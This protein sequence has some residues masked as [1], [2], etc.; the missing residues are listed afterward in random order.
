MQ[1]LYALCLGLL[2]CSIGSAASPTAKHDA[3]LRALKNSEPTVKDAVWTSPRVLKVGVLDTGKNR[4]G[5]A[6]YLCEVIGEHGLSG[7]GISVQVIDIAK[8]VKTDKW[9]KL[10]E[11]QCR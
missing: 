11:R 9:V 10:G 4:D 1:R 3:V 2:V 7:E 5:Y 6:Q 8:L